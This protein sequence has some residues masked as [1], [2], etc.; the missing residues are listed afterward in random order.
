MIGHSCP[1]AIASRAYQY[2]DFAVRQP[3]GGCRFCKFCPTGA[4]YSPDHVHGVWGEDRRLQANDFVRR[5]LAARSVSE[6]FLTQE[7]TVRNLVN[8]AP[9][10]DRPLAES[11]F[12]NQQCYD[13]HV[14]FVH[15]VYA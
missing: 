14:L 3:C 1:R 10:C 9:F 7:E 6:P 15:S 4:R 5:F 12:W 2:Q 11:H 13:P 8:R